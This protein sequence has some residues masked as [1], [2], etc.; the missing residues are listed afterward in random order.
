MGL[1]SKIIDYFRTPNINLEYER[2]QAIPDAVLLDVREAEEY[3]VKHLPGSQNLPLSALTKESAAPLI[4]YPD[5][6]VFVY[7]LAGPCSKRAKA[8][9][10]SFGYVNI[11]EMGGI[12][13]YQGPVEAGVPDR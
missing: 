10:K 7:C 3:A 6:P 13:D 11:N 2:F 1:F 5:T 9:L 12:R 8:A 4:R